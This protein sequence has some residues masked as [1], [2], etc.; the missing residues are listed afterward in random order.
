MVF[1]E[2]IIAKKEEHFLVDKIHKNNCNL[3]SWRKYVDKKPPIHIFNVAGVC[4]RPWLNYHFKFHSFRECCLCMLFVYVTDLGLNYV[5]ENK[6][7]VV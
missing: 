7:C 2:F 6:L 1:E 5:K 3:Q 4:E